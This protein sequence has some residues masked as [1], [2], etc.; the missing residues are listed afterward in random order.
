MSER[1]ARLK[2]EL[3]G[4]FSLTADDMAAVL[5]VDRSTVYRYI[6][7]GALAALKI[8]REYRLSE[9]DVRA[10]LQ[11]LVAQERQRVSD[12]RLRALAGTEGEGGPP[13]RGPRR[14]Q[15]GGG[16]RG[17]KE[18]K[19]RK[20]HR[21]HRG[22]KPG[23]AH[24]APQGRREQPGFG[25]YSERAQRVVIVAQAAAREAG[26]GSVA[27]QHLLLALLS[28][29]VGGGGREVLADLGVDVA[30]LRQAA[31]ASL[32]APAPD[33]APAGG[34]IFTPAAK[35]VLMEEAVLAARDLGHA[36]VGTEHLLLGLFAEPVAA[37]VLRAAGAERDAVAAAVRRLA[38]VR[39]PGPE[40]RG[41]HGGGSRGD[42]PVGGGALAAAEREARSRGTGHL[43]PAHVLLALLSDAPEVAGGEGRVALDALVADQPAL[44]V[45]AEGLLPKPAFDPGEPARLEWGT[46]VRVVL[47]RARSAAEASPEGRVAGER[48]SVA[49]PDG[50]EGVERRDATADLLVGLYADPEVAG[51]LEAAGA[52][53]AA[54]R[55]RLG[56][57]VAQGARG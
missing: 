8:G 11:A 24:G 34:M 7:D 44:R 12:L 28:D 20:E 47:G 16:S 18:H 51:V 41:P 21:D 5:E 36:Y 22:G 37:G 14:E 3:L 4:E 17:P 10:F 29:E 38:P 50:P 13:P 57:R 42:G 49:V 19:E 9:A 45:A 53:E 6:Q 56:R 15:G 1:A 52:T 48:P 27:P 39:G 40:R 33:P 23:R 43:H 26:S 25:R 35:A 2:A 30:G 31:A 32:P 54:V 46:R 55:A